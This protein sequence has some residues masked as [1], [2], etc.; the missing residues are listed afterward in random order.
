VSFA[1]LPLV[2]RVRLSKFTVQLA[3]AAVAAAFYSCR[4][5][6]APVPQVLSIFLRVERTAHRILKRQEFLKNAAQ[7]NLVLWALA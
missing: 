4:L 2:L 7:K 3:S 6:P 5:N 1:S